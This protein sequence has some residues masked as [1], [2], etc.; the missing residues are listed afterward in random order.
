MP[1]P[2]KRKNG[3]TSNRSI[4]AS[5][6]FLSANSAQLGLVPWVEDNTSMRRMMPS[7]AGAVDSCTRPLV[8][9]A[10]SMTLVRLTALTSSGTEITW[11]A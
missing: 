6:S 4:C 9:R 8:P 7:A 2:G 11:N 3:A 5:D 1:E 10:I